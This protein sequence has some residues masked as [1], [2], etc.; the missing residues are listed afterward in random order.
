MNARKD[1]ALLAVAAVAMYGFG[2]P[3][4]SA[5]LIGTTDKNPPMMTAESRAR[6]LCAK[7]TLE[8]KA[9]ELMVYDYRCLGDDSWGAYTNLVNR[10]EI[11]AMMRVLSASETRRLQ[12]YKLAHSR[13]RIPLIIHE[14]ITHGWVT[15]LPLQLAMACSW[16]D[17]AVAKAEAVAAREAAA[18]GINLT[19]SPQVEVSNDPRWGRIGATLGEDPYLSGRMAAAR[20]RGDQGCTDEALADGEHVIACVKHFIGYSSL[21]GGKDYRHQ[22]FSRRE[23]FETHLPPHK[24]AIDAGALA[25]MSAYTAFDGVPCNFSRYLLTDILRNQLGFRGQLITDWTTLQFSVDEGA[26]ADLEDAAKRGLEAGVDM[27]MISR[28][29]LLLPKLVREGKVD[30]KVLDEAVVRSLAMKFRM[31]LFDDPFRYCDAAREKRELFSERN[32]KDVLELT[33]ESIVLLKNDGGLLPLST[34]RVVGLTGTWAD[35]EDVMRGG[36]GKD[37]F[38][39]G[40]DAALGADYSVDTLKTA[41]SRRW[42]DRLDARPIDMRLVARGE[43]TLPGGD[44]VVLALGEP[45][46]YTGERRGRARITLP[47]QELENLRILKRGGKKIVSVVFAGRPVI[48]DEIVWLSDAVIMAWY[49]G[50]MGGEALAEILSGAVNPSGKLA[51]SIPLDVGQIPLTYREKRTFIE[52]SYA[53]I[54]SKPLFPFGFGMSYTTFAYGKPAAKEE[55]GGTWRVSV[56]V[57]NIGKLAG[58]EIVQLYLRDEVASVLPRERELKE[59]ASVFLLPGETK[60]VEFTLDGDAFALYNADLEHVVEPGGFTVFVGGDSTTMNSVR[61]CGCWRH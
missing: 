14:D 47:E 54:P 22:D 2:G 15:T 52:C 17:A 3:L 59:F 6:E 4:D 21:Q 29:F 27:D 26:A 31:G 53:D 1:V 24:A 43:A 49:P 48:M 30:E 7:M 50:A 42:G 40:D 61:L 46:S 35:D 13:L 9:G 5:R 16:D 37:L 55:E 51:Q 44:I 45:V 8:E 28:A 56:D 25:V 32:K 19:Y 58:R 60:T 34:N 20:V 57:A 39:G 41:M 38:N 10:C 33:R 18:L 23:L 36:M 11:G 12:E